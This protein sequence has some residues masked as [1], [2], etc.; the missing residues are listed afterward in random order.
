MKKLICFVLSALL[1]S[2]STVPALAAVATSSNSD[3]L[4]L[5]DYLSN[6]KK[7]PLPADNPGLGYVPDV[8]VHT[9]SD[10]EIWLGDD[11]L[12]VD[13]SL[14]LFSAGDI[15]T[16]IGGTSVDITKCY[17][18]LMYRTTNNQIISHVDFCDSK[19]RVSIPADL[20]N[21]SK[22]LN[23]AFIIPKENI[24]SSGRYNLN[25][26]FGSDTGGFTYTKA[27]LFSVKRKPNVKDE[28]DTYEIPVFDQFSGD[29]KLLVSVE[30]GTPDRMEIQLIPDA[31]F[32]PPYSGYFQLNF[33]YLGPTEPVDTST[34]GGG[35]TSEDVQQNISSTNNQIA[36]NT[37]SM[38]DTLKEIVQ[39]ISKQL[40]AL[41]NQQY[42]YIHLEDMA[43]ADKNADKIVNS[44]SDNISD[45]MINDDANTD[46]IVNG[47][48]GSGIDSDNNRL[49]NSINEY[50]SAESAVLDKVNEE[51]GNFEFQNSFQGYVNSIA[52]ISSFLQR[53]YDNSGA[54]KDVINI[55]FFLSIAS[56]VIG[57][58]RFKEG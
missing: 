52:V 12:P 25:A 15:N 39:T 19:G 55:G 3:E 47:Y 44:I 45:Q 11:G 43:N 5:D 21:F 50:E 7:I 54:F 40:E 30:I 57:M 58:Y 13:D 24:P 34:A 37:A 9:S 20:V 23:I 18:K 14:T 53:L 56:I 46:T 33:S 38:N 32:K 8:P 28:V 17:V 51:L 10:V 42:N 48:D 49:N 6:Y 27:Q 35:S 22:A 41:W 1:V 36:Q 26:S 4:S 29:W 16:N 2:A 31:D